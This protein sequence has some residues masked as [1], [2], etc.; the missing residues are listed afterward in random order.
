MSPT[1]SPLPHG[2]I[3]L[4][5]SFF[6][7]SLVL[8][9]LSISAFLLLLTFPTVLCLQPHLANKTILVQVTIDLHVIKFTSHFPVFT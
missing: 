5:P 8:S 1:S 6:C 7:F 9:I 3:S 2:L 4:F